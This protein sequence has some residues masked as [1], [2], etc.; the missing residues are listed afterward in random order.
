M[1]LISAIVFADTVV[2]VNPG[3]KTTEISVKQVKSVFLGKSKKL[4]GG[5]AATP[6]EQPSG[7]AVR[8]IFNGKVLKKNERKLKAYWSKKVFSGKGKPPKQV[9]DDEAV[10][11]FVNKTAGAIGY[12]DS[13]SLDSSV[14]AILTIE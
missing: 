1:Y 3:S 13:A 9:A 7:S 11:A 4:P 6:V 12:I 10:K 2:I 5:E 8:E 14:K